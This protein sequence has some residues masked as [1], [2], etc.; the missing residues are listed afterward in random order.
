MRAVVG[1]DEKVCVEEQLWVA[2]ARKWVLEPFAG[3][4]ASV[5]IVPNQA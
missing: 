2:L 5:Q 1:D 3:A 4:L